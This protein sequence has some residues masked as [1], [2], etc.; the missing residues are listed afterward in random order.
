M[1]LKKDIKEIIKWAQESEE[2]KKKA[3]NMAKAMTDFIKSEKHDLT[4]KDLEGI[5]GGEKTLLTEEKN[6]TKNKMIC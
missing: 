6:C 5:F 4:D 1:D 3:I 2:N